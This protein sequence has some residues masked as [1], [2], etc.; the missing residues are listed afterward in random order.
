MRLRGFIRV[1]WTQSAVGAAQVAAA[2]ALFFCS[3][4]LSAKERLVLKLS[5]L[6]REKPSPWVGNI[7]LSPSG[8]LLACSVHHRVKNV[9]FVWNTAT[10]KLHATLRFSDE[11]FTGGISK[12]AFSA[13]EKVLT[14]VA[15]SQNPEEPGS[16]VYRSDLETEKT[17]ELFRLEEGGLNYAL[18]PNGAFLVTVNRDGAKDNNTAFVWDLAKKQKVLT[19]KVVRSPCVMCAAMDKDAKF[20]VLG[21]NDG[22]IHISH[23][24]SGKMIH[25]IQSGPHVPKHPGKG[26]GV[27]ALDISGDGKY[28]TTYHEVEVHQLWDAASGKPIN[29][30]FKS[31]CPISRFTPTANVLV[32][33][34]AS[35][36]IFRS[37][38]KQEVLLKMDSKA[39]LRGM[40]RMVMS[41]D[42]KTLV[43][44]TAGTIYIWT[45]PQFNK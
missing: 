23:F 22:E 13:D 11:P 30:Y 31:S 2:V 39:K 40:E 35:S 3:S 27:L 10:G 26:P 41:Q 21:G 25:S 43:T 1:F 45:I 9:V 8:K 44:A 6:I 12:M 29:K 24:P 15:T 42:G 36:L 18:S 17:I 19:Q 4:Q 37:V 16:V 7:A 32:S 33:S 5:D 28:V 38:D 34:D 20:L 14:T